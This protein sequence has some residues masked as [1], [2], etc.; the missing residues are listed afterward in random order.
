MSKEILGIITARAN[1]K[2]LP[3]KNLRLLY[4]KPLLQWT[5]DASLGSHHITRTVVTSD[6][7]DILK[8]SESLGSEI[9]RRPDE[10]A[11]DTAGSLD[12]IRHTVDYLNQENGYWPDIL[13]LLQPTS[14]LRTCED[15]DSALKFYFQANATAV[16]SGYELER[17]PLREFLVSP[18]GKLKAI[19][20]DSYPFAP[21]QH[22]P[23]TFHPNGAIYIID[24]NSFMT[25]NSLLTDQT[26]PFFMDPERSIDID[27][28]NDLMAAEDYLKNALMHIS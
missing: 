28:I 23:R 22:L 26:I 25:L 15:I 11:T 5:V 6:G 14:P 8:F 9:I 16:I 13:V 7:E 20:D 17:N 19:I 24:T 2:R 3:G 12:V 10:L 4:G 18:E 1:S 27:N 21:R